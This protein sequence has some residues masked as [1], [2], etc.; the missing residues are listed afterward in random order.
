MRLSD[1]NNIDDF[2]DAAIVM[3]TKS[4]HRSH[5]V[6]QAFF[7]RI[8]S[9]AI[10]GLVL[11]FGVATG[12]TLNCI[13]DNFPNQ[14]VYGFDWFQGLP[15]DWRSDHRKGHFACAV[16]TVRDNAELIIGL[17]EDTLPKFVQD[18]TEPT[19]SFIHLDADL[20]SST[21]TILN[22]MESRIVK[23][24]ILLFDELEY[25]GNYKDHEYKAF[26]EF[27]ERTGHVVEYFGTRGRETVAF[28]IV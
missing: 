10:P 16:P 25:P 27:L 22:N 18:H 2:L 24:T 9:E 6:D 1:Y 7:G 5:E 17:F 4:P 11:E 13:A 23:G 3:H 19:A 12:Y 28:R 15:E 14:T 8:A 21:V 26:R 20:Y